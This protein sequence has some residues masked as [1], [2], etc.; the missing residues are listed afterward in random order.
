M[1]VG[2]VRVCWHGVHVLARAP[3]ED[4]AK[5]NMDDA[6]VIINEYV[7]VMPI[8]DLQNE[9]DHAIGSQTLDEVKP[10]LLE[11]FA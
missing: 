6:S 7:A 9:A 3:V 8:L 5:I 4:E 11:C 1:H 2:Q 10:C